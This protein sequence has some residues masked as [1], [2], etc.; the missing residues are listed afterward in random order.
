MDFHAQW[1]STPLTLTQDYDPNDDTSVLENLHFHLRYGTYFWIMVGTLH[2]RVCFCSSGKSVN[3]LSKHQVLAMY[4]ICVL[5]CTVKSG[6]FL[7]IVNQNINNMILE[8]VWN[9]PGQNSYSLFCKM[10]TRW[11][12]RLKAWMEWKHIHIQQPL[13]DSCF[14]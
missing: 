14:Y 8:M 6:M 9:K 7:S 1:D 2:L 12:C 5:Q 11:V 10:K 13:Y 4:R 3:Y